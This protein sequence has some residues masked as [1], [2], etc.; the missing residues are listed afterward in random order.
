MKKYLMTGMAAF[1]M[2]AAF[3]SCSKDKDFSDYNYDKKAA[4]YAESFV[5]TFQ[6]NIDQEN[7][8]GFGRRS[9]AASTRT[10]NTNGNMWFKEYNYEE[11][12]A[13]GDQELQDVLAV[14]NERGAES[15]TSLIDWSTFFVQQVYKGVAEHT[16]KDNIN[17]YVGS[18]Q[19]NWL[20]ADDG[21]HSLNDHINDFNRGTNN[22]Y[23]GIMLM[24]G[25]STKA[26]GFNCSS[27]NGRLF[28]NFRME[29]IN[30]NY[31][32]GFD[33][34]AA[35]QNANEQVDRDYIYNDWIVKIVPAR[36]KQISHDNWTGRIFCEDLGA[37]GDF[38]FNDVVFD[39]DF[40]DGATY[41][42]LLAAGGTLPLYI[43]DVEVHEAFG[44]N[45]GDMVNTGDGPQKAP[46]ILKLDTNYGWAGGIPITVYDEEA[47]INDKTQSS[48]VRTL[49]ANKGEAPQK[50]CVEGVFPE[51]SPEH[52][53]IGDTYSLFQNYIQDHNVQWWVK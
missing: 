28:Y 8:W 16:A 43:G 49:V 52:I 30:G 4:Q 51:F 1:A 35:G 31:Y 12:P 46:V 6:V 5:K 7:D 11:I 45:V 48:H 26:F 22:D 41:I 34:E 21:T 38:D 15:Y 19:M 10:A 32:V 24:E 2:L 25:S 29:E 17:K 3:T 50:L 36:K 18:N 53:N 13:I 20:Y 33:F 39:Y 44:V 47:E 42:R 23:N 37:I 40:A 27:D 9:S 14:F